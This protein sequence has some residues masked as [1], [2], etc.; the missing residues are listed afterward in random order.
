GCEYCK[1]TGYSGRVAIHELLEIT[2]ELRQLIANR[3]DM[4]TIRQTLKK[5][6]MRTLVEDGLSKITDGITSIEEV[7]SSTFE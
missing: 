4:D 6:G 2:P 5:S 7:M 3:A 1:N